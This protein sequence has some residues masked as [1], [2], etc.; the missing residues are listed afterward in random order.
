MVEPTNNWELQGE[1]IESLGYIFPEELSIIQEK[2]YKLD[3]HINSNTESEERNFLKMKIHFDLQAS[4]PD[5]VP[6]FRLKNLSPDFMDNN[7]LDRCETLMSR[8]AEENIGQMMLFELAD[9]VKGVMT[10]VNDEVLAKL[11]EIEEEA[12]VE[13]QFKVYETTQHV[14]FTQVNAETFKIWC[15]EYMENLRIEREAIIDVKDTKLTG[16]QLFE[17]NKNTF[18]DLTLEADNEAMPEE[19]NEPV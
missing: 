6:Y 8:H 13:N 14:N 2:P 5:C 1:E 16:R 10:D 11:D 15:D 19:V 4:Y 3:I 18:E 17:M 7:F 9:I 12:K